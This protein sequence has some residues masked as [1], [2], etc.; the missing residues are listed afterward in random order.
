MAGKKLGVNLNFFKKKK[1]TLKW[2]E[3]LFFKDKMWVITV[4]LLLFSSFSTL[5]SN[6]KKAQI[7]IHLFSMHFA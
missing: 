1:D 5:S 2:E 7:W 6:M 4:N 3:F